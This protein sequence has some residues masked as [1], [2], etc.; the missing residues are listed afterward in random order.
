M[1]PKRN[2]LTFLNVLDV[3]V[4]SIVCRV[5]GFY[6][7]ASSWVPLECACWRKL[8]EFVTHHIFCDVNRKKTSAIVHIK[9]QADEVRSDR[10]AT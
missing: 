9:V 8:A 5:W 1:N 4:S 10:G 2:E 6:L 7:F 3:C